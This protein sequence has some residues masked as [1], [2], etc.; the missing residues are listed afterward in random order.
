MSAL[1]VYSLAHKE[2]RVDFQD[3]VEGGLNLDKNDFAPNG[4]P[5][6]DLQFPRV[7]KKLDVTAVGEPHSAAVP[8]PSKAPV[9]QATTQT[10]GADNA[11]L[12]LS[13][14]IPLLPEVQVDSDD[15]NTLRGE[16]LSPKLDRVA[17][18]EKSKNIVPQRLFTQ[19]DR[20][21]PSGL[22]TATSAD[23]GGPSSCV[24]KGKAITVDEIQLIVAQTVS[25]QVSEL[26]SRLGKSMERSDQ[27]AEERQY[28]F[29]ELQTKILEGQQKSM[30]QSTRT[31]DTF[32]AYLMQQNA[33]PIAQM[34]PQLLLTTGQTPTSSAAHIRPALPIASPSVTRDETST[35]TPA[36]PAEVPPSSDADASKDKDAS[37]TG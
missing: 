8:G 26:A 22:Y 4:Y 23:S 15:E 30:E 31:L 9:E 6:D 21:Q 33:L 32:L 12:N 25:N 1:D 37:A 19:P 16:E 29:M 7:F 27:R 35:Q 13:D 11:A 34:A 3:I 24:T 36:T 18:Q 2:E 14:S 10:A 17:L 5:V 28:N 20:G